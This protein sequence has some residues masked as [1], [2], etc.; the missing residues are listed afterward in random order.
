MEAFK[1]A[2]TMFILG[3]KVLVVDIELSVDRSDEPH[4][5]LPLFYT[6]YLPPSTFLFS[7]PLWHT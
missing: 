3:G 7:S 2:E 6:C 5:R 1:E 4:P